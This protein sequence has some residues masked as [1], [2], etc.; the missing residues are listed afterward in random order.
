MRYMFNQD[1]MK[2]NY[3]TEIFL[4]KD[5]VFYY[6]LGVFFTDGNIF[7][8]NNNNKIQ[9]TSKDLDWLHI[10]QKKLNCALYPT[11]DGHGNLTINSKL[12]CQILIDNGCVTS[13]TKIGVSS[14]SEEYK[15]SFSLK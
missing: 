9:L 1:I 13:E 15:A 11:K 6:L 7:Q 3:N 10:L 5:E 14:S 8:A 12:I 2:Y 4:K